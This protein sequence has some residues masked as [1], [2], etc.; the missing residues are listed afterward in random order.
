MSQKSK[1][2]ARMVDI[3]YRESLPKHYPLDV[4]HDVCFLYEEDFPFFIWSIR[5]GGTRMEGAS[6][7]TIDSPTLMDTHW[8]HQT[9][10]YYLIDVE[11]GTV[12]HLCTKKPHEQ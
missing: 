10:Q 8:P 11:K 9:R 2:V 12:T 7:S 3:S 6:S 1:I 4:A 5:D